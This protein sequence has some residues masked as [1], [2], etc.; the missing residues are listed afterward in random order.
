MER[1]SPLVLAIQSRQEEGSHQEQTFPN[2]VQAL[3][4]A[5]CSPHDFGMPEVS[6]LCEA[7][8]TD[9]EEVVLLLLQSRASPSRREEGS[10]DPI[11]IAIQRNSA[12]NVRRL[13]QY[14]GIRGRE[15]LY[16]LERDMQ[17]GAGST[18]VRP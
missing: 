2:T 12:A 5:C 7:L 8:R 17:E 10:N 9:D 1:I 18:D 4:W 13:P 11:F 6:P 14:S 3:L 15:R 16:R